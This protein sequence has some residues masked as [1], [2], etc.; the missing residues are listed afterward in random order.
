MASTQTKTLLWTLAGIGAWTLTKAFLAQKRR[1][2]FNE[3]TVIITGGSRGLGL[4][5]ARLLAREGANVAI[6]ARDAEELDR[7][8]SE[9]RQYGIDVYTEAC[10][11]TDKTQ[12][13]RF[14]ENVRQT[15]GPVDVLINNAGVII[16]SPYEH[17]TEADFREAMDINF[18]AAFHMINA[19]LPQMWGR[20]SGRIVNIASFGG[21]VAV[22]H[23]VSYSTSK[24]A[25]VGYS[26]GI[27]AE[28]LKDNV[29]VT[30]ICPGLIRTGSPRNAIYK[31]QNE[32]EYTV[33]KIGDS[34][35]LLTIDSTDCAREVIDACRYGE[36]ERIISF[37]AKLGAALEGIAP[38]LIGELTALVNTQLPAP[39]G[40]GEQRA[41]GRDS[42]TALSESFLTTLTDQAAEQNNELVR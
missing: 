28:L 12:I 34:L 33:F 27:R 14:V 9:L 39:G 35:P 22:P 6:C 10:D 17:A 37:P 25:L 42:E 13:E 40:I 4:E 1:I 32:K 24:F 20:K 5:M 7:A 18:W 2:D 19:V 23:L 8:A 3:K 31:G 21:K 11:L 16:V 15:L 41:Y 36:A 30:T 26:E 29:Y 38:N